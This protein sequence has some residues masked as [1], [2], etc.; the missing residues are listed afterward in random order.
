M[1]AHGIRYGSWWAIQFST[2][3]AVQL[4]FHLELRRRRTADTAYG[5]YLDVHLPFLIASV[6][7]NPILAGELDLVLS[8]SRGGVV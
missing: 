3:Y 2:A 8:Y 4:G 6:G 1:R 7:R 5:P